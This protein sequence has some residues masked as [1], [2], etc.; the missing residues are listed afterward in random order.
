MGT[1]LRE[2]VYDIGGGMPDEPRVQGGA[3]G[4]ALRRLRARGATSTCPSTTTRVQ[5]VGAI[6]GSGGLI[7]M[8]ETTCMV[9]I[10]RY[11]LSS[12]RASRAAMCALPRRH[13]AHARDPRP[14]LRGEGRMADLDSAGTARRGDRAAPR[15]AAWARRRPTR[16]CRRSATSATSTRRTSDRQGLPGGGCSLQADCIGCGVT[17]DCPAMLAEKRSRIDRPSRNAVCSRHA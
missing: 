7:V 6:M 15:S 17:K 2:I 16:C 11:F 14:H 5:E 13:A 1:T 3:D 10:A 12:R 9:D 4:R 8:D